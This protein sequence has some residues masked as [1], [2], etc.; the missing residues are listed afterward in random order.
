MTKKEAIVLTCA[1]HKGGSGKS[2]IANGI[3]GSLAEMGYKV[4]AIDGDM[5]GNLTT[6]F[7]LR[8]KRTDSKNFY[9]A[10]EDID[11]KYDDYDGTDYIIPTDYENIDFI[12]SHP[13][14]AFLE[15]ALIL[16]MVERER[17]VKK[18][19]NSIK[20][21][22][23]YDFVVFDTNPTL[24]VLNI[25]IFAATDY[26]I[27]PV[28]C[29]AYGV[30]GLEAITK[31]YNQNKRINKKLEI[32][33]IAM[34]RVDKRE[35]ITHDALEVVKHIFGNKTFKTLIGVDTTVKKAQWD[36]V[37]IIFHS[38]KSRVANQYRALTK[39]VLEVVQN[40]R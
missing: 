39:E 15:T 29:S 18:L 10:I 3:I 5:Q 1:N 32:A 31:F 6:S 25:N 20:E 16:K 40:S 19:I 35:S 14:M 23:I 4:L 21:K 36:E 26:L 17:Y 8:D 27:I 22:G 34:N 13:E 38:P 9:R 33:G 24:G 2:S 30:D 12:V 7:G 28:E 11:Q 37:P